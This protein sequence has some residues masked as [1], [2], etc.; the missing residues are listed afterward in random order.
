[1]AHV[2][3]GAAK[4]GEVA[5][6][7]ARDVAVGLGRGVPLLQGVCKY[8]W[9]TSDSIETTCLSS[10]DSILELYLA[11]IDGRQVGRALIPPT[12]VVPF[13]DLAESVGYSCA[14]LPVGISIS[15]P[16]TE[17]SK[18]VPLADLGT[19][20]VVWYGKKADIAVESAAY[21]LLGNHWMVGRVLRFPACC[22]QAFVQAL[23]DGHK[24]T[25]SPY[26]DSWLL[27]SMWR[28][29]GVPLSQH[30]PCRPNCASSVEGAISVVSHLT[31]LTVTGNRSGFSTVHWRYNGSSNRLSF[32]DKTVHLTTH[33]WTD[34]WQPSASTLDFDDAGKFEVPSCLM[35]L[36]TRPSE[37]AMRAADFISKFPGN[38]L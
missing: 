21:D 9:N 15:T 36:V 28:T 24:I 7:L 35:D 29:L 19:L 32:T 17:Y 27:T 8:E 26:I 12:T 6:Q 14:L 4:A 11:V 18:W 38:R 1:M 30:L 3:Y 16:F 23:S 10:P 33:E 34:L 37:F 20:S 22:I 13:I 25:C 5:Y 2:V 31:Q